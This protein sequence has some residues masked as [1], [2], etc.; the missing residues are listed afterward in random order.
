VLDLSDL[1]FIDCAN[2]GV[3]HGSR[4]AHPTHGECDDRPRLDLFVL[5]PRA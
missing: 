4:I 5:E 3:I 1:T 2:I